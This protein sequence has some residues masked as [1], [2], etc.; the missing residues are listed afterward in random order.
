M[1]RSRPADGGSGGNGHIAWVFG[2]S[3]A[4]RNA[5]DLAIN[6]AVRCAGDQAGTA[7]GFHAVECDGGAVDAVGV[8][9]FDDGELA[10]AE[11]AEYQVAFSCYW[12]AV[13]I[14]VGDGI[15]NFSAV[16]GRIV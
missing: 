8:T 15:N 6:T 11:R 7:C 2:C 5:F 16:I 9:A 1:S 3:P 4:L 12:F 14:G 10:F 13:E